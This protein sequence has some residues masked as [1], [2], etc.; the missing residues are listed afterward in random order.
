VNNNA[1]D[2][3][4]VAG[5]GL[6]GY[7]LRILKFETT[8]V[9]LGVILGPLMEEYVRR[10]LMITNGDFSIFVTRPISLTFMLLSML[11]LA[12]TLLKRPRI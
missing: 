5:F 3:L 1:F 9:L 6:L 11:L 8:P 12:W 4:L 10:A 2:I 7:I